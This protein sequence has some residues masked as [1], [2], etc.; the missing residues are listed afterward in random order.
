MWITQGQVHR[1]YDNDE[2]AL[3][4]IILVIRDKKLT[5]KLSLKVD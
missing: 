4:K 5:C 3:Y 1:M 2:A